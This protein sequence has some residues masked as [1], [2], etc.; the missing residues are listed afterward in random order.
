MTIHRALVAALAAATLLS[1]CS[2]PRPDIHTLTLD[3]GTNPTDAGW[4]FETL[5][6][7]EI[8]FDLRRSIEQ[9]TMAELQAV[10]IDPMQKGTDSTDTVF[11][12][13]AAN[14][15][16]SLG[17]GSAAVESLTD[18]KDIEYMR[19]SRRM[20][21]EDASGV[22]AFARTRSGEWLLIHAE[23]NTVDDGRLVV[24]LEFEAV[25]NG[26]PIEGRAK[27]G[28]HVVFD[29]GGAVASWTPRDDY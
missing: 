16:A 8:A 19:S 25:R 4:R 21:G 13:F 15:E 29:G 17:V 11:N 27:A 10:V 5:G 7:W 22:Q 18:S 3:D 12:R 2:T 26:R 1:G 20:S 23:A 14:Y 9:P 24:S 28:Y 6:G